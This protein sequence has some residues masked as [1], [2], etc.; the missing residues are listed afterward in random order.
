MSQSTFSSVGSSQAFASLP[1]P[2]ST[3]VSGP[4]LLTGITGLPIPP[5]PFYAGASHPTQ[6]Q[7]E[8]TDPSGGYDLQGQGRRAGIPGTGHG[9]C[10]QPGAAGAPS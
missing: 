7:Q 10:H 1:Y 9:G 6:P 4:G 5:Y 3:A 2:G 8:V